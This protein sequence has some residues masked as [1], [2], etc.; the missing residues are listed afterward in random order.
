MDGQVS[1]QVQEEGVKEWVDGGTGTSAE[2]GRVGEQ[3]HRRTDFLPALPF[4][5]RSPDPGGPCRGRRCVR[6]EA[7]RPRVSLETHHFRRRAGREVELLQVQEE[8][9]QLPDQQE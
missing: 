4:T 6:S 9:F 5:W 2:G 3:T 8:A 7:D 1:E